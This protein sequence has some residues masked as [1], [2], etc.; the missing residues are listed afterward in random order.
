MPTLCIFH[1]IMKWTLYAL[2]LMLSS[3]PSFA[4]QSDGGWVILQPEW[5]SGH[6]LGFSTFVQLMGRSS[7]NTVDNCIKS[8]E[9]NVYFGTDPMNRRF[10]SD[11]AD[12]PFFLRAYYAWKNALPFSYVNGVRTYDAIEREKNPPV[13]QPG[14]EIKPIDNRYSSLGN[15]TTSRRALIPTNTTPVDFFREMDRLQNTL[16]SA[17][18]RVGPESTLNKVPYDFYSPDLRQGQIRPGTVMYDPNGHIA[19]VYEVLPDGRVLY[20]DAHP[21]NSVTRGVFSAKFSRARP[22]MGAGFKNFRSQRL[23]GAEKNFFDEQYRGGRIVLATDQ[24]IGAL[25]SLTQYYGNTNA[26]PSDWKKGSFSRNGRSMTFHEFVRSSIATA[27]L[28]PVTEFEMSL[29]ELCDD[30]QERAESVDAA[31]NKSIHQKPH[32]GFLP[33][34]IFGSEGEWENYS[35]P[36]RD[37]RLRASFLD[38]QKNANERYNQWLRNDL[39]DLEYK[40]S[41]LKKDFLR[42]FHKVNIQCSVSYKGS[43]SR[44]VDLSYEL[45]IRRLFRMS[46]DPYHCPELRWG[47]THPSELAACRDDGTKRAWYDAEQRVR[48]HLSRDWASNAPITLQDLQSGRF[49]ADGGNLDLS[50]RQWLESLPPKGGQ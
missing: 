21:D 1:N 3:T 34:N 50:P 22:S 39:G 7:C 13:P 36:G 24:E 28:N 38:L 4:Q 2:M 49:G 17:M 11:C 43:D 31:T 20:M 26:D 10:Y 6:E 14:E 42:A 16:S 35:T 29:Q 37:T 46:F 41:D 33:P 23:V 30:F 19:V 44:R 45:A 48:N 5:T 8:Q 18:L 12:F 25:Q 47:A 15:Y 27:K 40:G 32:P 9:A